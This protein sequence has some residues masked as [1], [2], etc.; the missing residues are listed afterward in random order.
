MI[1]PGA[2]VLRRDA[3]HLQVGTSPA[4]VI[5]DHPG[6]YALLLSLD[7][8][9]DLAA[10]R[11]NARRRI[12]GLSLD[13][14][15]A[16]APLMA[17]GAVVDAEAER[18]PAVTVELVHDGASVEL[19]RTVDPLLRSLGITVG[20]DANLVVVMS[21]SEPDRSVL[22][23]LVHCRV[24]H[25]VVVQECATVRV[26]PL[27]VPG[28]TPCTECADLQRTGWDPAWMALVPQFGRSVPSGVGVLTRHAAAAEI[29][30]ACLDYRDGTLG[31]PVVS[32]G[33]DR[34]VRQLSQPAFHPRCACALL[35][36]A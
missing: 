29:A 34:E 32:I 25:L 16:L 26:G 9:R 14:A 20:T 28:R 7:G 6:L 22:S 27:V 5:R 11:R 3:R 36:A 35:E 12:P 23:D 30:A 8:V 13:V 24:D 4:I 17:A 33:E 2:P 21:S 31:R 1:R 10:L 15:D 19:A 18:V